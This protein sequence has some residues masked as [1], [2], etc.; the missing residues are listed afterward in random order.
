M[1]IRN[2]NGSIP[3]NPEGFAS[4]IKKGVEIAANHN[5]AS[6]NR[7]VKNKGQPISIEDI[8]A[9]I[10]KGERAKLAKGITLVESNAAH[11]FELAQEL[12]TICSSSHREIATNWDFW[13]AGSWEEYVY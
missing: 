5:Q 4:S 10:L 8:K 11:H 7:F 6:K 9:G 3:N 12:L 2:R 1:K 13:C